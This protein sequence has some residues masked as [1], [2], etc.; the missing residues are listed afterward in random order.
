MESDGGRQGLYNEINERDA[1]GIGAV[2]DV[3]GKKT[4]ER[5]T[6]RLP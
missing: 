1:C 3:E 2:V 6:T 5:L 4:H